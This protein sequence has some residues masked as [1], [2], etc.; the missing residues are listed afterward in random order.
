MAGD[1][2]R[3]VH[4]R[5]LQMA[6][7]RLLDRVQARSHVQLGRI[8]CQRAGANSRMYVYARVRVARVN[9][10]GHALQSV[11]ISAAMSGAYVLMRACALCVAVR[12]FW[13][14]RARA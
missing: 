6:C 13:R 2:V 3:T 4:E 11:R 14:S 7:S 12:A 9:P 1:A 5:S 8:H 10:Y